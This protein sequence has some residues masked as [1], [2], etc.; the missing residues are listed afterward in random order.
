[1]L[2]ILADKFMRHIMDGNWIGGSGQGAKNKERPAIVKRR[3]VLNIIFSILPLYYSEH[4]LVL[5]FLVLD[6]QDHSAAQVHIIPESLL[7]AIILLHEMLA[8]S[9]LP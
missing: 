7:L 9:F 4:S 3:V 5:P 8:C 6:R 2:L 1:M